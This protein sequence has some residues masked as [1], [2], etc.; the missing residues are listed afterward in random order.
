MYILQV[1]EC[2]ETISDAINMPRN[3]ERIKMLTRMSV[4]T[5]FIVAST[6]RY[7]EKL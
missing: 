6:G 5:D 1:A 2:I 3:K 7:I 4:T